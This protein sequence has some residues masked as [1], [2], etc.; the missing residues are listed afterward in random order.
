MRRPL[1][2]LIRATIQRKISISTCE[3]LGAGTGR[4]ASQTQR[5]TH[6][7]EQAP[8]DES[9]SVQSDPLSRDFPYDRK[10]R[11]KLVNRSYSRLIKAT[12]K[13]RTPGRRRW[14]APADVINL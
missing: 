3:R 4:A 1:G 12:L 6:Q 9:A 14:R 5:P 8:N 13:T 10:S 7:C 2:I 11:F